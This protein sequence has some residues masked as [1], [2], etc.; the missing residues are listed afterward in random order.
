[1]AAGLALAACAAS[2]PPPS[3]TPAESVAVAARPTSHPLIGKRAPAF[4]LRGGD[5]ATVSNASIAGRWTVIAFVGAWCGDCRRDAPYL[6]ALARAV[7]QDPDLDIVAIIDE[8]ASYGD[9]LDAMRTF[10]VA[11]ARLPMAIDEGRKAYGAFQISWLPSY[12][13]VDPQ[14]VVRA[15]R[16]DLSVET[17]S[18]GGVKR[19]IRDIAE[20]R[21]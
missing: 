1:M 21:R 6:A 7:D 18:E 19:F 17:A 16:T 10:S 11:D 15:F 20:L 8:R 2:V 5:G 12:L 9:H 3:S 14:G 4:A 13:V